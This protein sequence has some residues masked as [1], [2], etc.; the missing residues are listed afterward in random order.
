MVTIWAALVWGAM[1][2]LSSGLT[3]ETGSPDALCPELS[4]TR[5]AVEARLGVV[6]VQGRS[7]WAARYT[8]WH[9]PDQDSDFVRLEIID[10]LGARRLV[11]DLPLTGES[12]STMAN[13]VALVLDRYFRD[14]HGSGTATAALPRTSASA[15]LPAPQ[16]VLGFAA[17]AIMLP[18]RPGLLVTLAAEAW[19][20]RLALQIGWST[21]LPTEP[22]ADSGVATLTTSIP[23]R[24]AGGWA[25]Q[26]GRFHIHAGPELFGAYERARASD[27]AVPAENTRLALGAGIQG[28][29]AIWLGRRLRLTAEVAVD[30][31]LG[32]GRFTVSGIEVLQRRS[33]AVAAVG[34]A[35][36]TGAGGA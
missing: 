14:L 3:V 20:T 27:I 11:R 19:H 21:Y 28:G 7:G 23:V 12:C 2:G 18:A 25:G 26:L 6:G 29:V 13:I 8:M 34:I 4:A 30:R 9:V 5:A 24:L 36:A 10:P 17:G 35:Y 1:A 31:V 22:I 33:R 32:G 15:R 16:M